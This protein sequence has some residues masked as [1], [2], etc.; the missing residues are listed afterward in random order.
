MN[1]HSIKT[2]CPKSHHEGQETKDNPHEKNFSFRIAMWIYLANERRA[3]PKHRNS[4]ELI[5]FPLKTSNNESKNETLVLK[6]F[7]TPEWYS[8][9][10]FNVQGHTGKYN[11]CEFMETNELH[12]VGTVAFLCV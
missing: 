6:I 9:N 11:C 4:K 2:D 1:L 10:L 12:S 7:C 3:P 5:N 8:L